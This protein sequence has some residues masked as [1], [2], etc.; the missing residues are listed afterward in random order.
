MLIAGTNQTIN[1]MNLFIGLDHENSQELQITLISP[2]GDSARVFSNEA[3]LGTDNNIVTIF[4]DQA[5]SS[6]VS[7]RYTSFSPRI[8]GEVSLNSKFQGHN[9]IG[10]WKLSVYDNGNAANTGWLFGWAIQINNGSL[11]GINN[12]NNQIVDKYSL[13]QNF[14]NPFNPT[15]KISYSIPKAGLVQ[16]KIYDVL[17]REVAS[18]VNEFKNAGVYTLDFDGSKFSSGVYFYK[19]TSGDFTKVK[20]M[21]LIK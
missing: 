1:D 20:K 19:L 9:P 5:D 21:V 7:N 18:P 3:R 8:K 10:Y 6:L 13:S 12:N 2:D 11:T 14:P 17:G 4:D 16:L 15:T